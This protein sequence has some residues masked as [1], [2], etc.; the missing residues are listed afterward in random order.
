MARYCTPRRTAYHGTTQAEGRDRLHT[1]AGG[2]RLWVLPF[3]LTPLVKRDTLRRAG[4]GS[5]VRRLLYNRQT[6][7]PLLSIRSP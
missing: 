7:Y 3:L 5:V 4:K 1:A 6:Y 2:M